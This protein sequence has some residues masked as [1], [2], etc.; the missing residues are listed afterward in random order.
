MMKID[1]KTY[2]TLLFSI[3]WEFK[4]IHFEDNYLA[5]RVNF[6][7]ELFPKVLFEALMGSLKGMRS[8]LI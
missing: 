4:G 2:A 1:L 5:W 7:R 6:W 3:N 8:L